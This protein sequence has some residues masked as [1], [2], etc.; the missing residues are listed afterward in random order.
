[1]PAFFVRR[2]RVICDMTWKMR[3]VRAV[4]SFLSFVGF[5]LPTY[6]RTT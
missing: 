4:P 2:E 3:H 6:I 5:E 1:M